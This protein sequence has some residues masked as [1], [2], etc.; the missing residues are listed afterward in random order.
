[1]PQFD[2]FSFSAQVFWILVGFFL[3]YFFILKFFLVKIS[4]TLKVRKKSADSSYSEYISTR[5]I[6]KKKRYYVFKLALFRTLSI[7]NSI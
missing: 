3:F 7:P 4:E 1:M 6:E 2:F 5:A